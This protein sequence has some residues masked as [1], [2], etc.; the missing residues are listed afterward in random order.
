MIGASCI[1]THQQ[2][3][4][5]I[6]YVDGFLIGSS[7][8]KSSNIELTMREILYGHIKICGL[9]QKEDV[10][11]AFACGA[12]YGG[13]IFA[14]NSPRK[15]TLAQAFTIKVAPLHY[16]GVFA[17]QPQSMIKDIAEK[18]KLHAVQLHDCG[19]ENE[20][21]Q[22]RQILLPTCQI[23][24]A[25]NGNKPLPR[26]LPPYVDKLVV[27]N[28]TSSDLGGTGKSFSWEVLINSHLLPHLLI[29]GGLNE[30]NIHEARKIGAFGLDI[31]SGVEQKPGV[32]D[33]HKLEN[34][35]LKL[36]S[37]G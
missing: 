18:L 25:V 19:S 20:I 2:I 13:L 36:R 15:V 28:M 33:H 14:D 3:Q 31:N 21:A 27:D 1:S 11:K 22:L 5:L 32:K 17:N 10:L 4:T 6:P 12:T 37:K 24:L 9:T 8:S 7:L 16:V 34:V 29:A 26:T 23:W 35:F 30:M